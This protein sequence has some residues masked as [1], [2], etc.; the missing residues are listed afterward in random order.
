MIRITG[1]THGKI[2]RFSTAYFQDEEM[3]T[4][5]DVL[6][7]C[8]DFGFIWHD[9]FNAYGKQEDNDMLDILAAK[10]YE[11]LFVD[12]NH[13]NFDELYRYP[14]EERY[15]APVHKIR[16]NIYH[17]ERGYVY[18]IQG[19]TFFT[20]G[21]AYSYDKQWRLMMRAGWWSQE[22]PSDEEYER[23]MASLQAVDHKVDYILTHTAPA[24]A[25]ERLKL[26]LPP[27]ERGFKTL[28]PEDYRLTSTLDMIMH[29]TQFRCWYCGHW[30]H[31]K[32][33]ADNMHFLYYEV[34][35]L[36]E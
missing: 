22:Q 3:W 21:G 10:P 1:D 4:N 11:I 16:D 7:V 19:K 28:H 33:V 15:G 18:T 36:D 30:H 14:E 12:G 27:K 2:D 5:E 26:F 23:A 31:D 6:I 35:A 20:F 24:S 34:V 9:H 25:V 29:D 17:L 8:G 32:K 13:E